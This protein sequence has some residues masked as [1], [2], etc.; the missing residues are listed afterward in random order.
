METSELDL[1]IAEQEADDTHI[2]RPEFREQIPLTE[3]LSNC[4]GVDGGEIVTNLPRPA[5]G[6]LL[7]GTATW[8]GTN[9]GYQNHKCRCVPCKSAHADVQRRYRQRRSAA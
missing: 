7:I 5:R 8:H 2:V 9:G 3:G 4:I 6:S 1:L